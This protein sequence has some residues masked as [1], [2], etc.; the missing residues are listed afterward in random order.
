M[1]DYNFSVGDEVERVAGYLIPSSIVTV[2]R[3]TKTQAIA[4]GERFNIRTGYKVGQQ[5]SYYRC[6]IRPIEGAE[7]EELR[8][9]I[10]RRNV[11]RNF[12]NKVDNVK[13]DDYTTDQLARMLAIMAEPKPTGEIKC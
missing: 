12:C 2:E 13:I 11:Y 4:G 7:K 8:A 10:R 9:K 1:R 6:Y 3:V 5:T